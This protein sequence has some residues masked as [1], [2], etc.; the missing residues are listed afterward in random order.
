MEVMLP[1]ISINPIKQY[2]VRND[3]EGQGYQKS[4][5]EQSS[6]VK[7]EQ[8]STVNIDNCWFPVDLIQARNIILGSSIAQYRGTDFPQPGQFKWPLKFNSYEFTKL[9]IAPT[10]SKLN[11]E[12]KQFV[13]TNKLGESVMWLQSVTPGFFG[14]AT[15]EIEVLPMQEDDA[16]LLALRVFGSFDAIEFRKRRHQLC[17]SMLREGHKNLHDVISV[18]QR[19]VSG[20]GWKA[21]SWRSSI[22]TQ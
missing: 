16:P 11:D 15:F 7:F 8:L 9:D 3:C 18:F 4:S 22:F 1:T 19:R 21:V 10:F 17:E 5:S 2:P 12:T 13:A 14:G 6:I 20:N